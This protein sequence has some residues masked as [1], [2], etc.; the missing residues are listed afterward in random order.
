MPKI[1]YVV[2]DGREYTDLWYDGGYSRFPYRR[3][4][5]EVILSVKLYRKRTR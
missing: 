3:T 1:R 4:I 2:I 5:D